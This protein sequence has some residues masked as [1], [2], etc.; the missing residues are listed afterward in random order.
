[1]EQKPLVENPYTEFIK[2]YP[3]YESTANIDELRATDYSRIDRCGQ[4]YLV[5]GVK[6]LTMGINL[7][8]RLSLVIVDDTSQDISPPYWTISVLFSSWN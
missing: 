2:K 5:Y 7:R 4:V 6:N 1:M 3:D 8:R